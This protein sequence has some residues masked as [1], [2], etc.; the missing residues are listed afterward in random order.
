MLALRRVILSVSRST[1]LLG[2]TLFSCTTWWG[3]FTMTYDT[4]LVSDHGFLFELV[5][6]VIVR[7][8]VCVFGT[9]YPTDGVP[10]VPIFGVLPAMENLVIG[11]LSTV[12]L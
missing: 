9:G 10:D 1:L 2:V 5:V 6:F 11:V 4:S 8:V 7:S 3:K 12:A